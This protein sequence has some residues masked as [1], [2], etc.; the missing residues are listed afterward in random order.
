MLDSESIIKNN[1]KVDNQ[2]LTHLRRNYSVFGGKLKISYKNGHEVEVPIYENKKWLK[3]VLHTHCKER[4][5]NYS[6]SVINKTIKEY[7][8]KNAEN[9]NLILLSYDN[10]IDGPVETAKKLDPKGNKIRYP[11]YNQELSKFI[12]ILKSWNSR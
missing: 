3:T 11:Y 8:N 7:L 4:F 6:D 9:N 5:N 1:N 10:K 12:N 2:L